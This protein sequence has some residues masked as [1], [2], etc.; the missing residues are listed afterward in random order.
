MPLGIP[1]PEYNQSSMRGISPRVEDTLPDIDDLEEIVYPSDAEL[2][3]YYRRKD[4]KPSVVVDRAGDYDP[5]YARVYL[6]SKERTFQIDVNPQS[7]PLLQKIKSADP[8]EKLTKLTNDFKRS[9]REGYESSRD[10]AGAVIGLDNPV[11]SK[12]IPGTSVDH[13]ALNILLKYGDKPYNDALGFN[14]SPI[15]RGD[16]NSSI[17]FSGPKGY[18][19]VKKLKNKL[20]YY[21]SSDEPSVET[22]GLE[23]AIKQMQDPLYQPMLRY[24]LGQQ[25]DNVDVGRKLGQSPIG[26]DRSARDILYTRG[27]KGVLKS[28]GGN[29]EASRLSQN[30][31]MRSF[32]DAIIEWDPND[33]KK[34][35]LL[36][37]FNPI[38]E[39]ATRRVLEFKDDHNLLRQFT[40]QGGNPNRPTLLMGTPKY[41][42]AIGTAAGKAHY[43]ADNLF[44]SPETVRKF[45]QE[46][47]KSAIENHGV[48]AITS[49]PV[50]AAVAVG[51]TALPG[52][53]P[54][55]PGVGIG[56]GAVSLGET[57]DAI[58]QQQTGEGLL[59]KIQQFI[60]T[61][62]RTGIASD[63]KM[64]NEL[65]R[66]RNSRRYRPEKA[67]SKYLERS[68]PV[69]PTIQP[70]T[71]TFTDPLPKR[72]RMASDRFNPSRGEFGLSEILFGR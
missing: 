71:Y 26:G 58:S 68:E 13:R 32:D 22:V 16:F 37:T 45:Y 72:V 17:S 25:I 47:P 9:L 24:A 33:L 2:E 52:I 6:P 1:I 48:E 49:L 64:N 3:N 66:Y 38:N 57:A 43:F 62:Q 4:I 23:K 36:K 46:S 31:W 42:A 34:S 60:G 65:V 19:D 35:A 61:R 51:A 63:K 12:G 21:L 18:D 14:L 11:A 27:T 54:L 39:E 50:S 8:R 7:N 30:K 67:M 28:K 59:P 44:P 10:F 41:R 53:A 15:Y 5:A 40:G 55:I 29:A 69:V 70:Q 56:L 20:N